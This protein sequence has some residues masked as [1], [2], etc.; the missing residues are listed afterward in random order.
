MEAMLAAAITRVARAVREPA[1]IG[2]CVAAI[3]RTFCHTQAAAARREVP[4]RRSVVSI[5]N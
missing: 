3:A 2:A 1:K 5:R 4:G